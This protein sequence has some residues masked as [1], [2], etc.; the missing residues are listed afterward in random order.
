LYEC[1]T[2][3][4]AREHLHN[5]K[6]VDP[7]FWTKL[8][9]KSQNLPSENET[10]PEDVMVHPKRDDLMTMDDSDLGIDTLILTIQHGTCPPGIAWRDDSGLMLVV[11]AENLDLGFTPEETGDESKMVEVNE[12]MAAE[13]IGCGKQRKTRNKLYTKF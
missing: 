1:L 2:G 12:P 10:L 7:K 5:L 8:T 9:A 6:E 3:F 13:E 11:D 4:E